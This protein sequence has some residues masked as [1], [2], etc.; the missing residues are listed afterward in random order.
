MMRSLTLRL[1]L[2]LFAA[3]SLTGCGATLGDGAKLAKDPPTATEQFPLKAKGTPDELRLAVHS[4]GLSSAQRQALADLASR[5]M[6]VGG[7]RI[8]VQAPSKGADPAATYAASTAAVSFLL[9]A[10][11]PAERLHRVSYDPGVEA[12]APIIVGFEAYEAVTQ[13]CGRSWDN[14]VTSNANKPSKNFGCA[15][16]NN[17]AAQIANPGDIVQ[18]RAMDAPD[19]ARRTAVLQKYRQ[20]SATASGDSGASGASSGSSGGSGAS[21]GSS[22]SGGPS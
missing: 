9:N 22:G 3:V 6:D 17:M 4:T 11:V 1:A 21:G 2:P 13:A 15:L 16:S 20:G 18:P 8:L 19:A 10:G 14:L 5:W 7:G 12:P